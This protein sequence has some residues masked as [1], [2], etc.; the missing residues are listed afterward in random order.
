MDELIIAATA[1]VRRDHDGLPRI[2]RKCL[3]LVRGI[4]AFFAGVGVVQ[5]TT[6]KLPQ[7]SRGHPRTGDC[8]TNAISDQV[9]GNTACPGRRVAVESPMCG[10]LLL[11]HLRTADARSPRT[12]R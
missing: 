1:E 2:P 8:W 7:S 12:D 3:R 9:H 6:V 4:V 10:W 11:G 5:T